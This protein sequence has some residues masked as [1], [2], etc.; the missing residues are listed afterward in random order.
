MHAHTLAGP[1]SL[2]KVHPSKHRNHFSSFPSKHSSACKLS[3]ACRARLMWPER[4]WASQVPARLG[5]PTSQQRK[6][7]KLVSRRFLPDATFA[8]PRPRRAPPDLLPI[9]GLR[10]TLTPSLVAWVEAASDAAVKPLL[11][12]QAQPL[13]SDQLLSITFCHLACR[14]RY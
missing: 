5:D 1:T 12:R 10:K 14:L 7:P 13:N 3:W 2:S 11:H 9:F 8:G 6:V 4:M